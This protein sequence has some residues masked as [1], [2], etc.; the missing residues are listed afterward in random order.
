MRGVNIRI[1]EPST[2]QPLN[3][4]T[5]TFIRTN[6]L[7]YDDGLTLHVLYK[8]ATSETVSRLQWREEEQSAIIDHFRDFVGMQQ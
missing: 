5:W 4:L 2:L 1:A 8:D 7:P 6:F 3:P